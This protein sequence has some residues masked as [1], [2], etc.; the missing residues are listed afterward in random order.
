[1]EGRQFQRRVLSVVLI[2][3]VLLAAF[4]SVL[5][6]LQIVHGEDYRAQSAVKIANWETVDAARGEILDRYG[7]V[8]VSNRATYQ[9]TLN[10][11]MMGNEAQRNPTLLELIEI[12][13]ENGQSWTDRLPISTEA[14][15]TYTNDTPL[16]RETSEGTVSLTDFGKLLNAL[17]LGKEVKA[18]LNLPD[19]DAAARADSL[20]DLPRQ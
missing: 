8:L 18:S 16:A 9:I 19:T 14:P 5:Y 4:A 6:N 11:T 20:D 15:F 3:I 2:L 13:R 17:P 12:C 10:T 1:M 7:R